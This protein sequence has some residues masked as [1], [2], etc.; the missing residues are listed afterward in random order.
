[1]WILDR[2][3]KF[4]NSHNAFAEQ[5]E[6]YTTLYHHRYLCMRWRGTHATTEGCGA[7]KRSHYLHQLRKQVKIYKSYQEET[8]SRWSSRS[9]SGLFWYYTIGKGPYKGTIENQEIMKVCLSETHASGNREA[10]THHDWWKANWWNKYSK[11]DQDGHGMMKSKIF[12][13]EKG[14]SHPGDE[15]KNF[16]SRWSWSDE[17]WYFSRQS[18]SRFR[19]HAVATTVCT[20]GVHKHSLVARTFF[21]S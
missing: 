6:R 3:Q 16:L 2:F 7:P 8:I 21:C 15:L 10:C 5:P 17:C 14:V 4:I 12:F 13:L 20:M 1:M 19:A 9:S 18:F 11:K